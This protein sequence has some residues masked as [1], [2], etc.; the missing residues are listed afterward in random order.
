MHTPHSAACSLQ[1]GRCPN[2]TTQSAARSAGACCAVYSSESP[3]RDVA[4]IEAHR[5]RRLQ[6]SGRRSSARSAKF[7]STSLER[8]ISS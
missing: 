3:W 1:R 2:C 5:P 8:L 4:I 6:R 7:C